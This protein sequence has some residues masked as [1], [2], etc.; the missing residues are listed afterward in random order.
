M[1]YKINDTMREAIL[2]KLNTEGITNKTSQESII[3]GFEKAMDAVR[4][5]Y[6]D[7]EFN[8]GILDSIIDGLNAAALLEQKTLQEILK[9]KK[10]NLIAAIA[11]KKV[12]DDNNPIASPKK[13]KRIKKIKAAKV[14]KTPQRTALLKRIAEEDPSDLVDEI[15]AAIKDKT[16]TKKDLY[17]IVDATGGRV[18]KGSLIAAINTRFKEL[19]NDENHKTKVGAALKV[20]LDIKDTSA[21]QGDDLELTKQQNR[22]RYQKYLSDSKNKNKAKLIEGAMKEHKIESWEKAELEQLE[23][24]ALAVALSNR[25]IDFYKGVDDKVCT[26]LV[27]KKTTGH[28][29]KNV[30]LATGFGV[31]AVAA[32]PILPVVAVGLAIYGVCKAIKCGLDYNRNRKAEVE[33]TNKT[34]N[35]FRWVSEKLGIGKKPQ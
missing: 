34:F 1:S 18:Q 33:N 28:I 19:N 32:T 13:E 14:D 4:A 23:E 27:S 10:A 26:D 24:I 9:D 35:P 11:T 22:A 25:K 7:A 2:L 20:E 15:A 29:I 12:G 6:T 30:T 5:I 21:L 8:T 16:F 31:V 17:A 3:G